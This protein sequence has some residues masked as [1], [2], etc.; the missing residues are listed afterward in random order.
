MNLMLERGGDEQNIRG[1]YK[2]VRLRVL[3]F[4]ILLQKYL[5]ISDL[6]RKTK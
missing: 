6:F 2:H 4:R 3:I 1:Y 5:V